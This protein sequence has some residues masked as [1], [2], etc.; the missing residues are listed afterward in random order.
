MTG[1]VTGKSGG[2]RTGESMTHFI[3]KDGAYARTA[4][5][6]LDGGFE[7]SWVDRAG[8]TAR[9]KKKKKVFRVKYTCPRCGL[10]AW[11]KAGVK[12]ECGECQRKLKVAQA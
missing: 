5:K 1:C 4:A 8:G 2:N 6:L 11:A 10:N 7:L 12:L 3:I 9:K